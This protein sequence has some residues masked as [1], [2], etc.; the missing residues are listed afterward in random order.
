MLFHISSVTSILILS[1]HVLVYNFVSFKRVSLSETYMRF[2]FAPHVAF[3]NQELLVYGR[4][5]QPFT[6]LYCELCAN[7]APDGDHSQYLRCWHKS[8]VSVLTLPA[9]NQLSNWLHAIT[10]KRKATL[11]TGACGGVVV[12]A[13]RYQS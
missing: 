11:L 7:E 4:R 13:L 12:K 9:L 5:R 10:E 3:M 2:F 8:Q 1:S 6:V